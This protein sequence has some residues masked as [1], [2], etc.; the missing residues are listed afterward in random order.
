[1]PT[2]EQVT[3]IQVVTDLHVRR[4]P[5]VESEADTPSTESFLGNPVDV[6]CHR[7]REPA[8]NAHGQGEVRVG[9]DRFALLSQ[10][11]STHRLTSFQDTYYLMQDFRV[12]PIL[13]IIC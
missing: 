3:R 1:M 5:R 6:S 2:V 13:Q 10:Q 4:D 9:Q 12:E 8:R 7:I 11:I